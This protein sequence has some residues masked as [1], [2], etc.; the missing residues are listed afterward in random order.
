MCVSTVL[1]DLV[2]FFQDTRLHELITSVRGGLRW[3][4]YDGQAKQLSGDVGS[5]VRRTGLCPK[6]NLRLNVLVLHINY[7]ALMYTFSMYILVGTVRHPVIHMG[8]L[9]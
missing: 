5:L 2:V 3:G 6:H 7:L 1:F 8:P 4:F 9:T